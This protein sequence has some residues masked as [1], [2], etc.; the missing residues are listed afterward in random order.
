MMRVELTEVE[1]VTYGRGG[2]SGEGAP[3]HYIL[4]LGSQ[5]GDGLVAVMMQ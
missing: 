3:A 2:N 1:M 4:G 5:H